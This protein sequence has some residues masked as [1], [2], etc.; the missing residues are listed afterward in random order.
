MVGISV[1]GVP[2][3]AVPA[4]LWAAKAAA[5]AAAEAATSDTGSASRA[6]TLAIGT[7]CATTSNV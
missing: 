7:T 3:A 5:T 1:V 4:V 6:R 2:K